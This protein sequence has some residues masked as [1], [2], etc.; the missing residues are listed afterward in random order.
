MKA[1]P[2]I[3]TS[4]PPEQEGRLLLLTGVQ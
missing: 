2:V 1:L 4:Q 3:A